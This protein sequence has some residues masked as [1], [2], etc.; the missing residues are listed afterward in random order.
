MPSY[1]LA[2]GESAFEAAAPRLG[3]PVTYVIDENGTVV[4]LFTGMITRQT[5][6]ELVSS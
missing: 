3:L 4:E 5:L 6:D 1:D 2:I